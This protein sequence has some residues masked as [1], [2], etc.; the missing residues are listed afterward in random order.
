MLFFQ[1]KITTNSIEILN[2]ALKSP[3]TLISD[4]WVVLQKRYFGIFAIFIFLPKKTTFLFKKWPKIGKNAQKW[5]KLN[6]DPI[7]WGQKFKI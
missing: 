2:M 7:F 1:V 6:F 4:P 3:K 5:P